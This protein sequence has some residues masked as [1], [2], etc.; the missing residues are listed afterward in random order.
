MFGKTKQRV[1]GPGPMD[2]RSSKT[3]KLNQR[4]TRIT[5]SGPSLR[6]FG[7]RKESDLT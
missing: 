7:V 6:V 1:A 2:G 3:S 5:L 4:L